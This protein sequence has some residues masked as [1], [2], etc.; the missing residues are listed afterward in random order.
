MGKNGSYFKGDN[1]RVLCI[2]LKLTRSS[3]TISVSFFFLTCFSKQK[4]GLPTVLKPVNMTLFFT[5]IC[6]FFIFFC[7]SAMLKGVKDL[8]QLSQLLESL[9]KI[10][11]DNVG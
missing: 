10:S 7:F 6:W 2:D 11:E 9:H 3:K 1:V 5:V 4:P 8:Q